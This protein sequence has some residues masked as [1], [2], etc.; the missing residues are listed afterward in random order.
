MSTNYNSEQVERN[1]TTEWRVLNAPTQNHEMA[2]EQCMEIVKNSLPPNFTLSIQFEF[3]DELPWKDVM[4]GCETHF[5]SI[6]KYDY[7]RAVAQAMKGD[8]CVPDKAHM[9]IRLDSNIPWYTGFEEKRGPEDYD[10]IT[11]CLHEIVH[12]LGISVDGFDVHRNGGTISAWVIR[13]R[14]RFLAFVLTLT[15]EGNYVPIRKYFDKPQR[16]GAAITSN[17]LYFGD[18]N[19]LVAKLYAPRRY[20]YG[21]SVC[22]LDQT[23]YEE[24]ENSLMTPFGSS[25]ETCHDIGPITREILAIMR[26]PSSKPPKVIKSH[27]ENWETMCVKAARKRKEK[28]HG[29]TWRSLM[30]CMDMRKIKLKWPKKGRS[31]DDTEEQR[32]KTETGNRRN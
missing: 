3:C 28:S 1:V 12:G 6:G 22:H 30:G 25:H 20:L 9:R 14:N 15:P 13:P 7:T 16:L 23:T 4:A 5:A 19:G 8:Y 18:A 31:H 2:I 11:N 26:D 32:T 29:F 24:T 27:G 17:N 21:S 10:L